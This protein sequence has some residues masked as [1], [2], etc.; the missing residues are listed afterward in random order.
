VTYIIQRKPNS[1]CIVCGK[2]VYKRPSQI[3]LNHGHVYC[4]IVCYGLSCRREKFCIVCGKP[5][6]ARFN[7]KSCSRSCAN[8][9]RIGTTYSHESRKSKVKSYKMLKVRLLKIRGYRCERCGYDKYEILQVH[10]KDRN[11]S[12]NE[13]TNLELI[14]PNCHFEDHYLEHSWLRKSKSLGEV[15]GVV[16]QAGLENQ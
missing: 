1:K 8:K 9:L 5:I 11:S 4:G 12:N 6:L 3:Q 10:H 16:D 15:L 13:L 2:P 14:C 7:K